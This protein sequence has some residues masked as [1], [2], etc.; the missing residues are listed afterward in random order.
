MSLARIRSSSARTS[1]AGG[2]SATGCQNL[3]LMPTCSCGGTDRDS[4]VENDRCGAHDRQAS[5]QPPLPGQSQHRAIVHP[6][7]VEGTESRRSF[8]TFEMAASAW[9]LRHHVVEPVLYDD[10]AWLMRRRARRG[11]FSDHEEAPAVRRD[12]VL[13]AGRPGRCDEVTPLKE[14]HWCCRRSAPV[15]SSRTPQTSSRR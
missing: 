2:W 14:R 13:R 7:E 5:C 15:P 4:Q 11:R 9:N 10:H 12:V 1:A 3:T 6:D 8:T